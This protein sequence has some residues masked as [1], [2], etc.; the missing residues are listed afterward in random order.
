MK[1]MTITLAC[2]AVA[3]LLGSAQLP[4]AEEPPAVADALA[5]QHRELASLAQALARR[6][7][8]SRGYRIELAA[9]EGEE[10]A[11]AEAARET[12]TE[13]RL[14]EAE[15]R[16]EEAAREIAELTAQIVGDV[17]P[18]VMEGVSKGMKRAM[19]GVN[20][21][22]LGDAD[23]RAE[24]V[25]VVGVTPG[26]P[27]DEAGL[28]T[29]DVLLSVAGV[30]LD[31]SGDTSPMSKLMSTLGE[32]EA[33]DQVPVEYRRDGDVETAEVTTRTWGESFADSWAWHF[34]GDDG[35]TVHEYRF[36]PPMPGGPHVEK[37]VQI[38]R[39]RFIAGWGDMELVSLTPELGDY[40]GTD[41][42]MLVVR[43]PDDDTLGLED[44]DVILEV[45]GREP[46]DPG[47]LMR[48]LRSYE[49]GEQLSMT[50]VRKKKRQSIAVEIP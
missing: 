47:H 19:L 49:P 18:A 17:A 43:A 6:A 29:G 20:V 35:E 46:S 33:G 50:I 5:G 40:F 9:A 45:G 27:A 22:N 25:L 26:W 24:G 30:R 39:H 11:A 15:R 21:K 37:E 42:G 31:W 48:I 38:L 28:R 16:M 4:A 13:M 14:K 3:G 8:E 23:D 2:L 41:K 12:E 7:A 32:K 1:S 34:E 36:A 10:R 44:G